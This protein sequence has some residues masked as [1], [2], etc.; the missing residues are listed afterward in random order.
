LIA[1]LLIGDSWISPDLAEWSLFLVAGISGASAHYFA[2]L[3]YRHAPASNIAPL[4][5]TNLIWVT[6]AGWLFWRELPGISIWAGGALILLGG[7]VALR[8][9]T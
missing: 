2:A 9:R 8:A 3:A 4:E 1:L 5:Y 6:L 7:Y